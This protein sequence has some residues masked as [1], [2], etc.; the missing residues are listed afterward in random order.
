MSFGVILVIWSYFSDLESAGPYI[1]E[2][3]FVIKC[4]FSVKYP[5][6]W[7]VGVGGRPAGPYNISS[8]ELNMQNLSFIKEIEQLSRSK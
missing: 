3:T 8:M 2:H 7:W 4:T 1:Y 6:S 5:S